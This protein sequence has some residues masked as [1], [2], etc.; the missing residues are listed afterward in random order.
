MYAFG[1]GVLIGTPNNVANPT[2]LNFGLLQEV[3]LD[4]KR[5]LKELNGQ[6]ADPVAIGAGTRK[7]T[8]K[9][10][11]ARISGLMLGAF[12]YGVTPS[13]GGDFMS[14]AEAHS[15]PA[16][17]AYTITPTPP[18]SGTF[19]AD[20]GVVYALTGLPLECVASVTAAG[21]YSETD[22]VYT[23][24]SADASAA[25]LISYSYTVTT[26]GTQS[27][28]VPNPLIGPTIS[29]AGLF[30]FTDPTTNKTGTCEI[31]NMVVSSN[32]FGTKLEDFVMPDFEASCY[33]NAANNMMKWNFPDSF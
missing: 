25:V 18:N 7:T 32:S 3:T 28:L 17:T 12:L 6:Y 23:F 14:F 24:D 13:V 20:Q 30:Y 22:G 33:A 11:V 29:F 9:A 5:T 4:Q 1:A 27:I 10:K 26:V 8:V 31:F 2:P 21:Q 15:V 19:K 16:S